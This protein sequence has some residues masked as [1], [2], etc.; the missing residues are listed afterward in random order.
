MDRL[1][2]G[3]ITFDIAL[4]D[5]LVRA[6]I[7]EKVFRGG[8]DVTFANASSRRALPLQALDQRRTEFATSAGSSE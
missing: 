8:D 5:A 7:A 3:E 2:C 4:V 1:E 6:A